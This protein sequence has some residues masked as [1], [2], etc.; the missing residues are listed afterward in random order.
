M[1]S[2]NGMQK[3]ML[4]MTLVVFAF[5]LAYEFLVLKPQ[6]ETKLKEQ[7]AQSQN[8]T[9]TNQAPVQEAQAPALGTPAGIQAPDSNAIASKN[10]ASVIKTNKSIYEIDTL[11]RIAQVTLQE[12]KYINEEANQI[13]LFDANQ[14]RPLEVRFS[15]ANVNDEA[16]KV[17][18]IANQSQIDATQEKQVLV[19]T[20]NLS[21]T[22]VTKTITF[23]PDG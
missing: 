12:S 5:F 17:N 7:A 14:L 15:D 20:Q 11:G 19:L 8:V 3:R 9:H 23:Y 2:N 6:Q 18:V 16:F 4:I 21:T 22:T 13:K 10:I 1:N